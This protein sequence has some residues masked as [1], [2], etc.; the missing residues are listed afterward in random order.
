MRRVCSTVI[1]LTLAIGF[2][3]CGQNPAPMQQGGAAA[4]TASTNRQVFQ[5][6]GVVKEIESPTRARI[7][8]EEIPGYMPAMTMPLDAKNTNE[9]AGLKP[10][11][12]I[13]FDMVVTG[14]DG[15]IEK[16]ARLAE[17]PIVAGDTNQG[18]SFTKS[19]IVQPLSVGDVVPDYPFVTEEG[20]TVHL[21]EFKGQAVGI[22]FIFTR[23]PFPTFCPRMSS[24]FEKAAAELSKAG[25]PTNWRLLS[26]SF[27]PEYDTPERLADY[28]KKFKRDSGKWTFVTSEKSEIQAL[29]EQLGLIFMSRNGMIEHNLRTAIIDANGRLRDVYV[30]NEWDVD[31]FVEEM[32]KAAAPTGEGAK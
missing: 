13:T 28:A 11:D 25:G 23:C 7:A 9:L 8:H 30:G 5:V 24:N 21:S 32:K 1:A 17:A 20:K 22:T 6:R 31:Q 12:Q 16:V 10:G 15:W 14:D 4:N 27:D 2:A 18:V 29:T 19:R 3:G 26:I